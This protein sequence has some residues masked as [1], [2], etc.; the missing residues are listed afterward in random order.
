MFPPRKRPL[1]QQNIELLYVGNNF[2]SENVKK[3]RLEEG[4][5]TICVMKD[6]SNNDNKSTSQQQSCTR[7]LA[8]ESGHFRHV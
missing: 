4:N 1:H 5:Q 8:G 2:S 6:T 7:C 3:C